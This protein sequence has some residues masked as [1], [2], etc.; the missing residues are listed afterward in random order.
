M[1]YEKTD[2]LKIDKQITKVMDEI[3]LMKVEND[4]IENVCKTLTSEKKEMSI[5]LNNLKPIV[6][7]FNSEMI[8][9]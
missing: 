4:K 7:S 6:E 3:E 2:R 8:F 9:K 5:A 1:R